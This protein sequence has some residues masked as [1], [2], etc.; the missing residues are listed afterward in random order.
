MTKKVS[1]F[2]QSRKMASLLLFLPLV[3]VFGIWFWRECFSKFMLQNCASL[4]ITW[5]LELLYEKPFHMV[6]FWFIICLLLCYLFNTQFIASHSH[7]EL[8]RVVGVRKSTGPPHLESPIARLD[9]V[10][11]G[12]IAS[13]DRRLGG[14]PAAQQTPQVLSLSAGSVSPSCCASAWDCSEFWHAQV[15]GSHHR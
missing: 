10:C 6:A 3:L 14:H 11:S 13:T 9:L 2:R 1:F 7:I 4:C 12:G 8:S 5:S 15:R